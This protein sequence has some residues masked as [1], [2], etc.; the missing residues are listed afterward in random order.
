[1][2]A[3]ESLLVEVVGEVEVGPFGRETFDEKEI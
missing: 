2:P 3:R 1:M